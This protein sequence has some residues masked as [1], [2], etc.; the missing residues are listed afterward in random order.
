[1]ITASGADE[2]ILSASFV[3][4]Y[5]SEHVGSDALNVSITYQQGSSISPPL[6]I[7]SSPA[8]G[9][10]VWNITDHNLSGNTTPTITWDLSNVG[11]NSGILQV[12]TDREF[13]D[14]VLN[15][16]STSSGI[17]SI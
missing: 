4:F 11:S 6:V 9:T 16:D 14:I 7:Q 8:D 1:M 5:S 13:R 17:L 15:E 12:A 3:N 2:S 10:A